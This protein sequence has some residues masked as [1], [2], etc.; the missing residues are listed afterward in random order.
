MPEIGVRELKARASEIVRKVRDERVRYVIT[1]R[2]QPV[3]LLIPLVEAPA[4]SAN[5]DAVRARLLKLGEEIAK[6][7]PAGVDS[8][9]ALS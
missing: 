4:E 6:G 8:G 7:W 2:G 5:A 3:G 1:R 9:Q